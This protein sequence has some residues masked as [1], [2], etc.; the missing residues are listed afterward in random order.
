M[1]K[2]KEEKELTEK[3][4]KDLCTELR[5]LM[6]DEKALKKKLGKA[7]KRYKSYAVTHELDPDDYYGVTLQHRHYF[8]KDENIELAKEKGIAIPV[9]R[10]IVLSESRMNELVESGV[11]QE[12]EII[13][14]P[15]LKALKEI[16]KKKDIDGFYTRN[17]AVKLS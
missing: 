7:K 14:T 1:P 13:E 4:F 17:L 10:S 6:V 8:A 9:N 16:F 12:G 3:E 2:K 15:D 11:L 5:S